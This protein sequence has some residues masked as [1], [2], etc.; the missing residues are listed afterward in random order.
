MFLWGAMCGEYIR[1][2]IFYVSTRLTK[3]AESGGFRSGVLR[4]PFG[5]LAA[6][7]GK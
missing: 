1:E 2:V 4:A 6:E 5:K 7:A 3:R